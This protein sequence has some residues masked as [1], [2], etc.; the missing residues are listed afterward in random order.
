MTS[1]TELFQINTRRLFEG[2]I[3]DLELFI[4]EMS[5]E[6][7]DFKADSLFQKED[8]EF[9]GLEGIGGQGKNAFASFFRKKKQI[10]EILQEKSTP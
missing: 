10:F 5:E 3:Q 4:E 1:Y 7:S 9:S 8:D 2:K 6:G